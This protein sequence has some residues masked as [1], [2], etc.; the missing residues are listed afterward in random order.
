MNVIHSKEYR[1]ERENPQGD[2]AT[3]TD[4]CVDVP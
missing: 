2:E 4:Y 1:D 3:Q